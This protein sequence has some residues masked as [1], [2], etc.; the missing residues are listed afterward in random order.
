[1][2]KYLQLKEVYKIYFDKMKKHSRGDDEPWKSAQDEYDLTRNFQNHLIFENII[3]L[4]YS[5]FTDN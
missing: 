3:Q 5:S 4:N 1:M 2:Q